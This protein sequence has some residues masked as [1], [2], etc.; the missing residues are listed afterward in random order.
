MIRP[1][2]CIARS[3]RIFHRSP[4]QGFG[5]D[6]RRGSSERSPTSSLFLSKSSACSFGSSGV[7]STSA[8]QREAGFAGVWELVSDFDMSNLPLLFDPLRHELCGES[9][10]D[11]MHDLLLLLCRLPFD[12]RH[13]VAIGIGVVFTRGVAIAVGIVF[14]REIAA[15]AVLRWT[16]PS[17]PFVGSSRS[18]LSRIRHHSLHLLEGDEGRRLDV[19]GPA[20][21]A[22]FAIS[23]AWLSASFVRS[24]SVFDS[25][26]SVW[27]RSFAASFMPR[28]V[29]QR[30]SVP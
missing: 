30:F 26:C 1:G 29:A 15:R 12:P 22:A 25:S 19:D 17:R 4:F 8:A 23:L 20:V 9:L 10:E 6:P 7:F 3:Y 28:T 2:K 18:G 27:S 11:A 13:A 16:F 24:L 14:G 5:V 21:H